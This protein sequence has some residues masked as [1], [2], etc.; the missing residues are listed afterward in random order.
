MSFISLQNVTHDYQGGQTF[1]ALNEISFDINEGD[2]VAIV[3]PS[4]SGKST[5]LHILG[6][7]LKPTKGTVKIA[8]HDIQSLSKNELAVL[9]NREVGFVFQQFHLL[10]SATILEN[11]LLPSR[12]P[13]ELPNSDLLEHAKRLATE[14][15]I[16]DLLHKKPNQLS[17]GQQQ[18]VAIA[19][20]LMNDARII[21]AD[22]PTGNLDSKT[23]KT[24]L[25]ILQRLHKQGKTIILITHDPN[26]AN[27]CP[28][29]I[30]V[31]D[32]KIKYSSLPKS[33][34]I[35]TP[36]GL[37][38]INYQS[39]AYFALTKKLLPLAWQNIRRAWARSISTMLGITIGIAAVLAMLTFGT[40]TKDTL[41]ASYQKLGVNKIV[42]N[43]YHNWQLRASDSITNYFT[44]FDWETDIQPLRKIFP[45]IKYMSP[46][47]ENWLQ[48]PVVYAGKTVDSD[49]R[50]IGVNEQYFRI[51]NKSLQEGRYISPYHVQNTARVCLIGAEIY[52]RLFRGQSA[53]GKVIRMGATEKSSGYTCQIIGV[54][55][56]QPS[57]SDWRKPD[58]E[59]IMPIS[60]F[61][62]VQPS[63]RR[64]LR[65][66]SLQLR[67]G[68]DIDKISNAIKSWFQRKYGKAGIFS[69]GT[70]A[71]MIAQLKKFLTMFTLLITAIAIITLTVGGIGIMNLMLVSLNERYRE[72]G[73]RKALGATDFSIR[74]QMLLESMLL[75]LLAGI[76][77]LLIGFAAYQGIIY[78]AAKFVERLHFEWVFDIFA[79]TF[80]VTAIFAVGILSGFIP[81]LR[82]ERLE[83]IEALRHE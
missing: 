38:V 33:N 70:D 10:A 18:R 45:Q 41:L 80:A 3:G 8:G 79:F 1:R 7:L 46:M 50:V 11:I 29:K 54:L 44:G 6:C 35:V 25:E 28:H 21:L 68:Q 16:E 24:V 76:I 36:K 17:G 64:D 23:S 61:E 22:E 75:C 51:N 26:L 82:A 58:Y 59:I 32:G 74:Y 47:G 63:H 49:A 78:G 12:Y 66:V 31:F 52:T 20:A 13:V 77:G 62:V 39:S 37:P 60:Y 5:L 67:S 55:A 2:F 71:T 81:A 53:I 69:T 4:G 73:L 30:E 57:N 72:L 15:G 56:S 27:Q 34:G 9:R 83:I 43:G 65:T 42:L 40:F 48:S 19:R 14:L